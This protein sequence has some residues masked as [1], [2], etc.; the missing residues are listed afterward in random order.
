MN[1]RTTTKKSTIEGIGTFAAKKIKKG[2]LVLTTDGKFILDKTLDHTVNSDLLEIC[3]QTSKD[4]HY[5]PKS[6]ENM[7]GIF[8]VNH[9]C[10]PNCG[11]EDGTNLIALRDIKIGEEIIYDYCM[12]DANFEGL[13]CAKTPS[14][15]CLCG[16]RLCR[17]TITGDDWK[18][19]KLQEKYKGYFS[20][21]I[22]EMFL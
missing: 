9:S 18:S 12:T 4:Y 19:K 11:I 10:D 8:C 6:K 2:E 17:K 21:Y 14:F 7:N 13:L 20:K 22:E 3:F 1:R 5:C 15:K 16:F